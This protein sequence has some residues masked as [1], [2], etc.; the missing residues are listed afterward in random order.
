MAKQLISTKRLAISKA[1]AQTFATVA[2]ASVITVFCLMASKDVWS[3]TRYQAKVAAA[4]KDTNH[5]LDADI[6]AFNT[7]AKSYYQFDAKNPNILGGNSSGTDNNNGSNSH[8][9][10]DALPA[11]YDFP[12]LASSLEKILTGANLK[13]GSISGTDDQINQQT[14]LISDTPQQVVM[15]FTFS[16]DQANLSSTQQLLK[17]LQSSIRPIQIDTMDIGGSND[18]LSVNITAHTFYQPA[19]SLK[20]TQKVIK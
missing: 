10:L 3:T 12:A 11:S 13:I 5:K 20:F 15:P 4:D 18:N 17:T 1:N 14:N 8:I 7:L 19:K 16:I 9:I 6:K 2:I